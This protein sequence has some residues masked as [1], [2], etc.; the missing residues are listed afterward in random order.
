MAGPEHSLQH[1][2]PYGRGKKGEAS[3]RGDCQQHSRNV[4]LTNSSD[5]IPSNFQC[6]GRKR[7]ADE[8]R[9]GR[10]QGTLN[11]SLEQ[12]GN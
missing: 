9:L 4:D 3:K 1:G 5:V 2:N 11:S 12:T 10:S 6:V 8:K 7:P